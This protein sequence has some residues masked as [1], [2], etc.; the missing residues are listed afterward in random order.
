VAGTSPQKRCV[1]PYRPHALL[2]REAKQTHAHSPRAASRKAG[3]VKCGGSL[4]SYNRVITAAH[5]TI[6]AGDSTVT[7]RIGGTDTT[8]GAEYAIVNIRQ[9]EGYSR[10]K[11]DDPVNDLKIV[12]FDN[13]DTSLGA[14]A[15][16]INT[17]PSSPRPGSFLQVSGYGR[18]SSGGEIASHLRTVKV[19]IVPYAQCR[20][21][22]ADLNMTGN[23]CAGSELY[24]SCQGDSGG[25]LWGRTEQGANDS[26]SSMTIYGVVS[27]GLGC[28]SYGSPGV[29]TRV[30][31]YAD[32]IER[33]IAEPPTPFNQ[34]LRADAGAN[35]K[36]V[37]MVG[38]VVTVVILIVLLVS[39]AICCFAYRRRKSQKAGTKATSGVE[40]TATPGGAR[41]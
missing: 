28:A 27:Y 38:V 32:W 12:E 2:R 41:T 4:I 33:A 22:Y 5:C 25:P 9:Y 40:T 6:A 10:G 29:Y 35:R 1:H 14:K 34:Q 3:G 26:S 11:D 21:R 36:T 31:G 18:L 30:S 8:D 24:D 7:L 23:I 20:P 16:R 17:D 19:P 13:R 15:V 39:L 37:V